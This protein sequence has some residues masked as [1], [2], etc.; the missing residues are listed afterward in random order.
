MFNIIHVIC[1]SWTVLR[2]QKLDPTF[3]AKEEVDEDDL[4]VEESHEMDSDANKS[5][6]ASGISSDLVDDATKQFKSMA[7]D[8]SGSQQAANKDDAIQANFIASKPC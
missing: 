5:L 6:I 8:N 7:I 2:L 1:F 3:G 4:G